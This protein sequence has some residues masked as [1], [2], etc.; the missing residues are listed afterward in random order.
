M[1]SDQRGRTARRSLW[2]IF[3][4]QVRKLGNEVQQLAR[5]PPLAFG[6]RQRDLLRKIGASRPQLSRRRGIENDLAFHVSLR[7]SSSRKSSHR[8]PVDGSRSS[9]SARRTNSAST[10]G[11][12]GR[13]EIER[14]RRLRHCLPR[15]SRARLNRR[16]SMSCSRSSTVSDEGS[17]EGCAMAPSLPSLLSAPNYGASELGA[18]RLD[19]RLEGLDLGCD[20]GR[21]LG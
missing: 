11:S 6:P 8:M 21:E 7:S 9:A 1:P 18:R 14:S 10:S 15:A 19:R 12:S 16:S 20:E 4:V 5:H 13:F 3:L 17:K 2:C